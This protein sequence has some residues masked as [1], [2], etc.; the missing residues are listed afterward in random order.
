MRRRMQEC[1]VEKD[2]FHPV[3][4]E[5]D[6]ITAPLPIDDSLAIIQRVGIAGDRHDDRVADCRSTD[7]V[8]RKLQITTEC[9]I[10]KSLTGNDHLVSDPGLC[11]ESLGHNVP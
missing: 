7:D 10:E 2:R 11:V 4:L 5:P 3:F 1:R 9:A 6:Q 8:N